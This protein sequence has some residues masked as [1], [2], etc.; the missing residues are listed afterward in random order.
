MEIE[1]IGECKGCFLKNNSGPPY[2][3]YCVFVV[4]KIQ[5]HCPCLNC[6]VKVVCNKAAC[7]VRNQAYYAHSKEEERVYERRKVKRM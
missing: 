7:D 3:S 5:K 1:P 2:R 4:G 6:L